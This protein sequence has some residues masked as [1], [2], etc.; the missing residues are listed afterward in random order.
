MNFVPR[1]LFQSSNVVF[2]LYSKLITCQSYSSCGNKLLLNRFYC[3][4]M[5]SHL[6]NVVFV[7][8]GPGAGKGTQCTR[9]QDEFGYIHLSAGD[10]LREERARPG[11]QFGAL[12]ENCIVNGTIVPVSVTCSLLENRMNQYIK[13]SERKK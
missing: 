4:A 6:P 1:K 9:I 2:G 11:S 13:V 5:A 3:S 8:G 7:L 12:I 10:L